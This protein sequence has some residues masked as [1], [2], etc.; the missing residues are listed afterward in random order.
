MNKTEFET[1]FNVKLTPKQKEALHYAI[2]LG[3]SNE[4]VA[5]KLGASHRTTTIQHI[6]NI[7]IK[8]GIDPVIDPDYRDS[9][10]EL[11][12]KYRPDLVSPKYGSRPR[13]PEGAEPLISAFYIERGVESEC[14]SILKEPGALIRVSAPKEMGKT[15]L[16]KRIN[17]HAKQQRYHTAYLNLSQIEAAK[18]TDESTFLRQ[19]YAY[20]LRELPSIK[21]ADHWNTELSAMLNCT[22]QFQ[23]LLKQLPNNLVLFLD[24]VDALFEHPQIY[25]SFF[26]M[27]RHWHNDKVNDSENW[28]KLRLVIAY[29]TEDYGRLDINQS[30]FN[31]GIPIGLGN[32]TLEQT[33]ML[34]SRH[35]LDRQAILPL[36][37]LVEGHPYL[38]RL[39]FYHLAHHNLTL[40]DLIKEAPTDAG[41]YR[42]HLHRL[43]DILHTNSELGTLGRDILSN[44]QPIKTRKHTTQLMQLEGMGLIK[45]E[46]DLVRPRCNLYRLYFRDRLS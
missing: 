1:I 34:A 19:F 25:K 7:C 14:Y 5:Q 26:P 28:E 46:G 13:Y 6:K 27:L 24:E 37:V 33:Q 38:L 15:S 36:N 40:S 32:F 45:R 42:S 21:P 43:L 44:E 16:L 29:S 3:L 23:S 31:V 20:T 35:D 2:Q 41:I 18:L 12:K 9:L 4:D 30:P 39:G 8:F 11:L 22:D 10:V 17:D